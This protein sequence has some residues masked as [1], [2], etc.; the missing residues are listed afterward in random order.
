MPDGGKQMKLPDHDERL[1]AARICHLAWCA[2][3][4]AA[5][6]EFN[7]EPTEAQLV[8]LMD[9][10][11]AFAANPQMT[12]EENHENWMRYRQAE[13]W[14][15][16]PVKDPEAKT[17]PDLVPYGDLSEIERAKDDVD[18][19]ARRVALSVLAA[20]RAPVEDLFREVMA[21]LNCCEWYYWPTGL[22]ARVDAALG[23]EEL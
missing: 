12:A 8:S 10:L 2:Y 9:G 1:E 3:Q 22:K 13:G 18:L 17:H 6:Q 16:G 15:Y 5:G 11:A 7:E 21:E 4:M 14:V 19:M 20:A 23:T